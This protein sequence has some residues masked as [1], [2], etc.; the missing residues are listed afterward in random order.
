MRVA[1]M[2]SGETNYSI[3]RERLITG[4]MSDLNQWI[5]HEPSNADI[6]KLLDALHAD[7]TGT[8]TPAVD[9]ILTDRWYSS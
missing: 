5:E 2:D 1:V 3:M 8:T 9:R 7:I 4:E 6:L